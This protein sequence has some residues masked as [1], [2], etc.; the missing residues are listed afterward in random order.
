MGNRLN[1][2][3]CAVFR[4]IRFEDSRPHKNGFRAEVHH[5]CRVCRSRDSAGREIN[6]R[7]A[8]ELLGISRRMIYNK[9]NK[10]G[11]K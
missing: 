2:G 11:L 7:E 9:L 5:E 10:Y 4:I 6:N 8:A 3:F 1:N